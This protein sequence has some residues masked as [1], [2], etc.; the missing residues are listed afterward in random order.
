[1]AYW[2]LILAGLIVTTFSVVYAYDT[3]FFKIDLIETRQK[4][5]IDGFFSTRGRRD[6]RNPYYSLWVYPQVDTNC[7]VVQFTPKNDSEDANAMSEFSLPYVHLRSKLH[8]EGNGEPQAVIDTR[9]LYPVNYN[10]SIH[11]ST[12]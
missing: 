7:V 8:Q 10:W 9:D 12:G 6:T 1:M 11:S 4:D 5:V 3:Y 2:K